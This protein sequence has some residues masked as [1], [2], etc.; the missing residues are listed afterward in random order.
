MNMKKLTTLIF[1]LA[2]LIIPTLTFAQTNEEG[3]FDVDIKKIVGIEGTDLTLFYFSPI[4]IKDDLKIKS[5]KVRFYCEDDMTMRFIDVSKDSCNKAVSYQNSDKKD[6]FILF[7]N[8]TESSKKFTFAV[9]A[10][11]ENGKW[12]Y[13]KK[14]NFVW[15]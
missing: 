4:N 6:S 9:K 13:T 2:F 15:N 5:W 3:F 10:Y 11:D 1:L 8:K 14:S 7:E 12:I